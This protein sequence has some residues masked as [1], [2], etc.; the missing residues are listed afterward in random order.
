M[1]NMAKQMVEDAVK[2]GLL[3]EARKGEL[4][5]LGAHIM[6]QLREE[7]LAAIDQVVA[8]LVAIY[9]VSSMHTFRPGPGEPDVRLEMIQHVAGIV[10]ET[11]D[12]LVQDGKE[13]CCSECNDAESCEHNMKCDRT[14]PN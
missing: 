2:F 13:V 14:L 11:L 5:D 10:I 4:I 1:K 6:D 8:C 12:T 9:G 3:S 7:G